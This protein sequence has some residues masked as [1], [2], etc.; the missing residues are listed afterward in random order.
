MNFSCRSFMLRYFFKKAGE[1]SWYGDFIFELQ[2]D[3]ELAFDPEW[4]SE[5]LGPLV[6]SGGY[7][8][9]YEILGN[10]NLLW[11][12]S[13]AYSRIESGWMNAQEVYW[14]NKW[15]EFFPRVY[16]SA[17]SYNESGADIVDWFIVE[18]VS[19]LSSL[20][21]LEKL[22]LINFPSIGR[23]YRKIL[24][25]FHI[26]PGYP[27]DENLVVNLFLSAIG[28]G[29]SFA[30]KIGRF[31]RDNFIPRGD[32]SKEFLEDFILE[33]SIIALDDPKFLRFMRMIEEVGIET[34]DLGPSNIGV[35][36]SEL[37][38]IDISKFLK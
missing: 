10:K 24:G 25:D 16:A 33:V 29:E 13:D 35:R 4:I 27:E 23:A 21:E 37:L 17:D 12:V 36:S 2:G 22:I 34:W 1:R 26:H 11:K 18:R 9:A 38:I 20:E 30:G 32:I 5:S 8:S 28:E 7:R 31:I 3:G 15:K 6:G 19:P 14:F